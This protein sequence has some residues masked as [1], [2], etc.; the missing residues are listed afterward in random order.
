MTG[1][2]SKCIEATVSRSRSCRL[3]AGERD[4]YAIH[5][6]DTVECGHAACNTSRGNSREVGIVNIRRQGIED[7]IRWRVLKTRR[8][9]GDRIV[10]ARQQAIEDVVATC[11]RRCGGVSAATECYLNAWNTVR[12]TVS[13]A[14]TECDCGGSNSGAR[15][16][17]GRNLDGVDC[18][19]GSTGSDG[20]LVT[21]H[22]PTQLHDVTVCDGRKIHDRGYV[23]RSGSCTSREAGP[24]NLAVVAARDK[25]TAGG[26]NILEGTV[27]DLDL[28]QQRVKTIFEVELIAEA[29]LRLGCVDG[30]CR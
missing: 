4:S 23:V 18:S 13:D 25:A 10:T 12:R 21:H 1:Q 20:V 8:G 11:V 7:Q 24:T 16:R 19:P 22:G 28:Q 29:Y 26:R 15:Q 3:R 5:S 2:R 9:W 6:L 27:V 14:T 17:R 30:N